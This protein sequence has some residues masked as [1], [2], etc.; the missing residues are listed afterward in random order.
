[1]SDLDKLCATLHDWVLRSGPALL[2]RHSG[3]IAPVA[4]AV[5]SVIVDTCAALPHTTMAT[6]RCVVLAPPAELGSARRAFREIPQEDVE[7]RKT[8][9]RIQRKLVRQWQTHRF[10]ALGGLRSARFRES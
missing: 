5:S 9:R 8:N 6:R 2:A 4:Q 3:D 7:A 1:M 10:A